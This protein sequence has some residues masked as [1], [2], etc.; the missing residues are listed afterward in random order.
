MRQTGGTVS[1]L[2]QD[3]AFF[4]ILFLVALENLAGFFEGPGTGIKREVAELGHR[5]A[6]HLKRGRKRAGTYARAP[7]PSTHAVM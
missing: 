5:T 6:F 2:E 4:R 1:R 3:I 7:L